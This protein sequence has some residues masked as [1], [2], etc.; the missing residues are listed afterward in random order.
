MYCSKC[1]NKIEE[2]AQFCNKCGNKVIENEGSN[3]SSF[4]EEY[5][6]KLAK[7]KNSAEIF[8]NK[9]KHTL[10]DYNQVSALYGEVEQIGS[11][12][13]ET[14]TSE[15]DFLIKANLLEDTKFFGVTQFESVFNN[16][17]QL[18][19][20]NAKTNKEKEEIKS[21]Y[22]KEEIINKY[23]E[24]IERLKSNQPKDFFFYLKKFVKYGLIIVA[25]FFIIGIGYEIFFNNSKENSN[26]NLATTQKIE[27]GC[28]KYE[29]SKYGA[30]VVRAYYNKYGSFSGVGKITSITNS[31]FL[32]KDNYGRY[33]FKVTFNYNPTNGN[34]T[35]MLDRESTKT[36]IAIYLLNLDN[37]DGLYVGVQNVKTTSTD[38][39]RIKQYDD[40]CGGAWNTPITLNFTD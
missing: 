7:A 23:K 35:T 3:T 20:L 19:L 27:Y 22:N 10:F 13:T 32:E 5:K 8:Y 15:L 40:L 29:N 36:V 4:S 26:S 37:P 25:V 24:K 11:H 34:G 17:L 31:E 1:G 28:T 18:A 38:W 9:E 2:G 33:A 12:I 16:L 14:Y 21:K 39:E 30:D 6:S